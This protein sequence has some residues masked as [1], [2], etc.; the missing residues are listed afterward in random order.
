MEDLE[1]GEP[2]FIIYDFNYLTNDQPPMHKNTLSFIYWSPDNASAQNKLMYATAKENFKGKLSGL[3][4]DLTANDIGEIDQTT[5]E[6]QLK[7]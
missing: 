5:I 4:A 2:R 1:K 6:D 3:Q 7:L